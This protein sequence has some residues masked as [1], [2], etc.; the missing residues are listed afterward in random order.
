MGPWTYYSPLWLGM[1]LAL[2]SHDTIRA[3]STDPES[4]QAWMLVVGVGAGIG[5]LGQLLLI[6][7]QGAFAQVLPVPRGRSIRGRGA[8]VGGLLIIACVALC[9]IAALLWSEE[10]AAAS[11]ALLAAGLAAGAGAIITYI[12]CWPVAVRDF[13][14]QR[15]FE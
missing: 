3:H 8:V 6:G 1:I 15:A 14:P 5:L 12:W 7:A 2:L 13:A 4:W 11:W 10:L 9:G